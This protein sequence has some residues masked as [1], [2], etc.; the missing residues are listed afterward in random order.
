MSSHAK[1]EVIADDRE[2]GSGVVDALRAV[3]GMSVVLRRLKLGDYLVDGRLLFERKRL[4]DLVQSIVDGRL[5]SQGVRLAAARCRAV[6]IL[7]GR[8]T[9]IGLAGMRREA[10]QGALIS[11]TVL[12]GIPILRSTSAEETARL[13]IYAAQQ[14]RS[15]VFGALARP[16]ARPKGKRGVQLRILQALPRVGP[17]RADRLLARFRS[18]ESVTGAEAAELQTVPGIGAVTATGV[19]WAVTEPP[20]GYVR[21]AR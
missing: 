21:L 9:A 15:P 4:A 16:G 3:R 5:L 6:I 7:E 1:I 18:V 10:I 2:A 20:S 11:L 8:A 13:M 17:V 12:M 19:R 14:V